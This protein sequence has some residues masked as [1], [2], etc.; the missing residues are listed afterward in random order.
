MTYVIICGGDRA[1]DRIAGDLFRPEMNLA[2]SRQRLAKIVGWC[3]R[4]A[5]G[6]SAGGRTILHY[7]RVLAEAPYTYED[8][9]T[10]EDAGLQPTFDVVLPETHSL[11]ANGVLSHKTTVALHAVA[12]AES[13]R[14]RRVHRRRTCARPRICKK[15]GVDIEHLLVS[16]PDTGEQALEIVEY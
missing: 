5:D 7:L 9:V 8:V 15:L 13:R 2:C 12:N 4:R 3:E 14:H 6:L 11:L 1:F 10:V 16:Q